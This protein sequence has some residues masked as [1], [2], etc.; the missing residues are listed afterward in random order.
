V[1]VLQGQVSLGDLNATVAAMHEICSHQTLLLLLP[2]M[3]P[4]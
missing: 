1:L 2:G 4:C 3:E